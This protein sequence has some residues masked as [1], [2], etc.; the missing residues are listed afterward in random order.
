[1]DDF[2]FG[3][4]FD[5][6]FGGGSPSQDD[7]SAGGGGGGGGPAALRQA[8]RELG[9]T[10]QLWLSEVDDAAAFEIADALT[11]GHAIRLEMIR[12]GKQVRADGCAALSDALGKGGAPR[13]EALHLS[14]NPLS[15]DGGAAVAFDLLRGGG[16]PTL[17]DLQLNHCQIGDTGAVALGEALRDGA[18]V[19]LQN[20]WLGGNA[21]GDAGAEAFA[22]ALTPGRG[23]GAGLR[24]LGLYSNV[25]GDR[26]AVLLAQAV[27]TRRQERVRTPGLPTVTIM[28]WGNQL[29]DPDTERTIAEVDA[30][31]RAEGGDWVELNRSPHHFSPT[32]AATAG[33]NYGDGYVYAPS[34]CAST[35][36]Y[37][38]GTAGV[39]W[40]PPPSRYGMH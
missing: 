28:L 7:G 1:M 14:G 16:C 34:S 12:L 36:P 4:F 27:E 26:G 32:A 40:T 22:A 19:A 39:P 21:I 17:R 24:R 23:Q 25:I 11:P 18:A 37:S 38:S 10:P 35:P 8:L 3:G 29:Q 5:S 9:R 13:L 31:G 33:Q 30:V 2:N 20:L 6:L 15:D